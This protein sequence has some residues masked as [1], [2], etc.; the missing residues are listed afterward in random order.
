MS[1]VI[2]SAA[3]VMAIPTTI[4]SRP[5]RT[6]STTMISETAA[7]A[8]AAGEEAEPGGAAVVGGHEADVGSEEHHPL[9]AD[10]QHARALGDHLA[11]RGQE[12]RHAGQDAA[13]DERGEEVGGEEVAHP[14]ASLRLAAQAGQVAAPEVPA[15]A[16]HLGHGHEDQD[17][18]DQDQRELVGQ[19]GLLGGE[20]AADGQQG[21]EGHE[22]DDGDRVEAGQEDQGHD[23][24]AEGRVPVGAHVAPDAQD[25]GRGGQADERAADE[26]AGHDQARHVDPGV[27]ARRGRWRPGSAGAART[28]SGP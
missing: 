15:A 8:A 20:V 7:P 6:Q 26:E 21:Q 23:Q 22:G 3:S 17:E 25:L 16:E 24:Q 10:V 14:G 4:W 5:K 27:R 18:P 28:T 2:P 9:E 12:Q 11:Q 19:A 1:A 13:G